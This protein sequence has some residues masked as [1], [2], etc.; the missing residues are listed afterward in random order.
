MGAHDGI[1]IVGAGL[2]AVSAAAELR[3]QGYEGGIRMLG[4]EAHPPYLRPPLSKGYLSGEEGLDGVLLHTEDWYRDNAIELRT[5]TQVFAV[6]VQE[7]EVTLRGGETLP[8]AT[9]LLAT[10]SAPRQLPI[11]G[12]ELRG[13]HYLRTLDDSRRLREQ[14]ARGGR[15]L[16]LIG[17]GWIGME[18]GA[19]ARGLGNEV[20]ILE[21]D[22]VP[23]ANAIGETLGGMFAG[24]HR[25][26]GVTI[27]AGALVDR[28]VGDAAGV[29]AVELVGGE[30]VPADLVVI[31]VGAGPNVGLAESAGLLA[32]DGVLVDERMRT[33]DPHVFAAGDIASAV[34]PLV[35][36]RLRSEHWAN[37]KRGGKAAA[38]G[39]LGIEGD[40]RDVPYF[41]TDQFELGMEYTGFAPLTVGAEIVYR[42]RP[43]DGS[44]IA[45]W[46]RDDRVVAGMNVNLWDVADDIAE[47]VRGGAA[48]RRID[49]ARLVDV[50][51][52]LGE[53]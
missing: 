27:R 25:Q 5:E 41:Y 3:A 45:F 12:A 40:Y 46:L 24:L 53:V 32:D 8:Y 28:I 18:V 10:G 31:G 1:V 2:A 48:G 51:V 13:V 37:A 42:G 35:R 26:K 7:R 11:D 15:R 16:V 30:Q 23:L 33:S 50:D 47:L 9:L 6:D 29:R 36:K 44:F 34:H 49:R 20:T 21:R 19:T 22:A 38:R 39:M 52:P 14:L 43:E 17:S 4:R